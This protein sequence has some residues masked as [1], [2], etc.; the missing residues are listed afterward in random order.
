MLE[1]DSPVLGP[2]REARN[3]PQNVV[4]AAE[5]IAELKGCGVDEVCEVTTDNAQRLF[6]LELAPP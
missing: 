2:D 3:E 5:A 6:R 4:V 1:T